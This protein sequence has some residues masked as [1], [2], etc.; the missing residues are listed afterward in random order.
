MAMLAGQQSAF[1]IAPTLLD[2]VGMTALYVKPGASETEKP[3][4]PRVYSVRSESIANDCPSS[5]QTL[6]CLRQV[7]I[8]RWIEVAGN[9]M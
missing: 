7:C 5:R 1:G 8:D 3:D 9:L 6:P 2:E 4:S